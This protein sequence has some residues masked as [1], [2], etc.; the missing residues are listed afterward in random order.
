[1]KTKSK[2]HQATN[3]NLAQT[4]WKIQINVNFCV[5]SVTIVRAFSVALLPLFIFFIFLPLDPFLLWLTY[6][7]H[8]IADQ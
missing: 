1:M 6:L 7:I 3:H 2:R 4:E 8:K 5:V